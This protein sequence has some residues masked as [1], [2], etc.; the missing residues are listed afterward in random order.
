MPEAILDANPVAI[1]SPATTDAKPV[2]SKPSIPAS[3]PDTRAAAHALADSIRAKHESGSEETTTTQETK[4]EAVEEQATTEAKQEE[5]AKD[6]DKV[7]EIAIDAVD[8]ADPDSKLPF[9]K[10]PRWQEVTKENK[11][12][13]TKLSSLEP[14]ATSHQ[15]LIKYCQ[16]NNI[17]DTAFSQAMELAAL[18]NKDPKVFVA[19]LESIVD[20]YRI[21]LGDK[22]PA[23]LAKSV[24]EGTISDVHAKEL[25]QLRLKAIG[26]ERQQGLTQEQM[27]HNRQS[28][29]TNAVTTWFNSTGKRDIN[30]ASYKDD[31]TDRLFLLANQTPP[32]NASEAIA[33]CER[34]YTD[35]RARDTARRPKPVARR[36]PI[37]GHRSSS[38]DLSIM[39]LNT[40]EDAHAI[41]RAV[42]ARH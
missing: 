21:T 15:G 40:R 32:M 9:H 11:E 26:L 23:D 33:L 37:N 17:T 8:T 20:T 18:A 35:V 19:K 7:E 36:A 13:Q 30:L 42:A 39:P 14:L 41:A 34:A 1:S 5:E 22:L 38:G 10:H 29:V 27:L 12:F 4:V 2:E 28:E 24:E 6:E 31:L 16:S 3:S 25:A